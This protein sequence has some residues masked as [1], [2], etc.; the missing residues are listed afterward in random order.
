[1]RHIT[2]V[3]NGPYVVEGD[4]PLA[5]EY[6][7][8]NEQGEYWPWREV[9]VPHASTYAL[10]RCGMSRTKPFC[11]GS[12]VRTGFDGTEVSDRPV[13]TLPPTMILG[14]SPTSGPGGYEV[15]SDRG[16]ASRDRSGDSAPAI[17]VVADCSHGLDGPL[18]VRGAI[19]LIGAD[20][21]RYRVC[22]QMRLCRCGTSANKPYCDGSHC[23]CST[24]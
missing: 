24:R 3:K 21:H 18:S 16:N 14:D 12:H 4:V 13:P 1:M 22:D 23:A 5:T 6:V 9:D 19:P 10:C 8:T 2:I 7:A 11:D 20:G 15:P 17:G